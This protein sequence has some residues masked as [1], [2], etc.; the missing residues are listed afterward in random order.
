M[1]IQYQDKEAIDLQPSVPAKNKVTD[2]DMNEIKNVVNKNADTLDGTVETVTNFVN[3]VDDRLGTVENTTVEVVARMDS[4]EEDIADLQEEVNNIEDTTYTKTEVNRFL[5]N[6]ANARENADNNLQNQIDGIVA[7]SDVVDIVGT[8][9]DLQNYDTS[10]LGD[11]DIIKVLSDNTHN[12]ATSYF[13]WKKTLSTWQYIGS[14]GP[15]YTKTESNSLLDNKVDKISG[16]GLSTND[17]TNALLNK[18][19][20]IQAGAQ[21]NSITGVKGNAESSYRTGNVNITKANIGLGNVDNTSDANKPVSNATATELNKKVNKTDIAT[22]LSS[23]STNSQVPGAKV[24]YDQLQLKENTSNKVNT[25]DNSTTHYPTSNAVKTVTDE[26]REDTDDNTDDIDVLKEENENQQKLLNALLEIAP[27]T[28]YEEG[29]NIT[30]ENTVPYKL[31]YEDDK[32][33]YGDTEQTT[34]E[35]YNLIDVTSGTII[36]DVVSGVTASMSGDIITINGTRGDGGTGTKNLLNNVNIFGTL[37][38]GKTYRISLNNTSGTFN[39]GVAISFRNSSNTQLDFIQ[40]TDGATSATRTLTLND[41]VVSMNILVLGDFTAS[42]F[43]FRLMLQDTT[44]EKTYEPFVGGIASPNPSYPQPIQVVTGEQTVIVS[45]KNK[46]N[47]NSSITKAEQVTQ[48]IIGDKKRI[49]NSTN[50]TVSTW[51]LFVIK[52]LTNLVGSTIKFKCDFA[53]SANNTGR[54]YIGLCDSSGNNRTPKHVST[55]SGSELS[56]VVPELTETNSYL[57][58]TLYANSSGTANIGD[59]VEYSNMILTIDNSDITYQPYITPITKTLSLGSTEL[60]K[61]G[62]YRDYIWT[63]RSAG[64]WYK[65]SNVVKQIVTSQYING[66][67]VFN[68][69]SI[70]SY[71]IANF[72]LQTFSNTEEGQYSY[73]GMCNY[74]SRQESLI[75]NTQIEGILYQP[76]NVYIRVKSTTASTTQ[77]FK[78]YVDSLNTNGNPLIIYRPL[79]VFIDTEITDTTLIEQLEEIYNLFSVDK[80]TVIEITGELPMIMKVR[81][82]KNNTAELASL[83]A[84]V[85]LLE[86]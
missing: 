46:F 18:L 7:S 58:V 21:V 16:K 74:F 78:T 60:C 23:S 32:V 71:G 34:Y 70:N 81:S 43:S 10:K 33:G 17:F 56:F 26:L 72:L 28:E 66:L 42:N 11:N 80:T 38:S 2:A 41:N 75:T 31:E 35:G 4:A 14:E 8:Y 53:V 37:T 82:L 25:L 13:R 40:T 20:S 69:Q 22:S 84:R 76:R 63:D 65:R 51:A 1:K 61:I 54:Y 52:D 36:T 73:E 9:Q 55:T 83:E 49:I 44:E 3:D 57:C 59:Y 29:S 50:N 47:P 68:L 5:T 64:K 24:T 30:L 12:N 15:Y 85:A 45:G 39:G 67:A 6:E 79:G 19:N 86:G 62:N 27:R 48:S 77:E